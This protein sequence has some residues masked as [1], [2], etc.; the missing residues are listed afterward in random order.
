MAKQSSNRL[1]INFVLIFC[2]LNFIFLLYIYFSPKDK[3]DSNENKNVV[4]NTTQPPVQPQASAPLASIP[5]TIV[6]PIV[7]ASGPVSQVT[8]PV[9]IGQQQPVAQ[10]P[11]IQ[12]NLA[13][14]YA[15]GVLKDKAQIDQVAEFVKPYGVNDINVIEDNGDQAVQVYWI[16]SKNQN[17]AKL[18]VQYHVP[19]A[20]TNSL[21]QLSNGFWVLPMYNASSQEEADAKVK[22]INSKKRDLILRT[23]TVDSSVYYLQLNGI[24]TPAQLQVVKSIESKFQGLKTIKKECK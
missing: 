13:Q 19:N 12:N 22:E 16:I 18:L 24:T 1:A 2:V 3:N 10:P 17:T 5:V 15:V 8:P 21:V 23:R 9:Q 11:V 4:S 7:T 6:Q 14:C 20:N